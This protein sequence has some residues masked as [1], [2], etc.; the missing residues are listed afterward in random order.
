[1]REIA[2]FDYDG[3]DLIDI[4]FT[5][6]A[7]ILPLRKE[8]ICGFPAESPAP[9]LSVLRNHYLQTVSSV[10]EVYTSKTNSIGIGAGRRGRHSREADSSHQP[11]STS[12]NHQPP[13]NSG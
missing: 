13:S 5:N 2:A 3:D 8:L 4:Y 12:Q 11:R 6:G 7:C 10:L 9:A 1:V